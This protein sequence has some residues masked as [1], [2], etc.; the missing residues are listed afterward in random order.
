MKPVLFAISAFFLI[1]ATLKKMPVIVR[2]A[3]ARTIEVAILE[4]A[5]KS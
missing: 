1:A 2:H 4:R 3:K 5:G